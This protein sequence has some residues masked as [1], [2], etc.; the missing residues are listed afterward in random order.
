MIIFDLK[1]SDGHEF[2][3]WFASR[4]EFDRERD[5]GRLSC[6]ICGDEDIDVLP[7]GGHIA[8]SSEGKDHISGGMAFHRAVGE[9]LAR[10]FEDVGDKFSEEAVKM[11]LGES[12]Q[13]NI[14]GTLTS[15]E[16]QSLVEDGIE[17]YKVPVTKLDS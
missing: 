3:G 16:E 2:E 1:C 9:Y 12:E 13:R 14:R 6:P 5:T 10:H 8:K 17:F 11:H 7:S 4:D 15:E